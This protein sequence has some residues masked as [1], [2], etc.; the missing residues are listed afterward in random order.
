MIG[1]R[2]RLKI[3]VQH[4]S[5]TQVDFGLSVGFVMDVEGFPLCGSLA[6][7]SAEQSLPTD[8]EFPEIKKTYFN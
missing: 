6:H 4:A 7:M 1:A 8:V 3:Q 5:I 2:A